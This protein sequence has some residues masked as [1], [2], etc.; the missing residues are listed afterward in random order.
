MF[1]A[2]EN[3]RG[4]AKALKLCPLVGDLGKVTGSWVLP[5]IS[6]GLGVAATCGVNQWME[7]LSIYLSVCRFEFS[8]KAK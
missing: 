7:D 1:V 2:W 4:E 6:S 5:Q 8:I 3:N